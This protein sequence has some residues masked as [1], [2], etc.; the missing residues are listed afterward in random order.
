MYFLAIQ[1]VFLVFYFSATDTP[2]TRPYEDVY[3][4]NH[5]FFTILFFVY[6][7]R[8]KIMRYT[9]YLSTQIT[10]NIAEFSVAFA[11][12]PQGQNLLQ[13]E[14]KIRELFEGLN[15]FNGISYPVQE[16]VFCFRTNDYTKMMDEQDSW[17]NALL[18]HNEQVQMKDRNG[19]GPEQAAQNRAK[20]DHIIQ[21]ISLLEAKILAVEKEFREALS[22]GRPTD[23][24]MGKAYVVF[25]T[26]LA[27]YDILEKYNVENPLLYKLVVRLSIFI[28]NRLGVGPGANVNPLSRAL[29]RNDTYVDQ[30]QIIVFNHQQELSLTFQ[31]QK[32][33]V[34]K[35]VNPSNIIWSHFGYSY[36]RKVALRSLF[37]GFSLA[38]LG[39]SFS[40]VRTANNA[41]FEYFKTH[42]MGRFWRF[43]FNGLISLSIL[44]FNNILN[45][46]IIHTIQF[47]WHEKRTNELSS[48]IK[49]IVL[50][51]FLNTTIMIFLICF[52]GGSFD[53]G[54]LAYQVI[55]LAS[56]TAIISPLAGFWDF[57]YFVKLTR[58]YL[59]LKQANITETQA[60]LSRLWENPEY[61][62]VLNYSGFIF[63]F[64]N[65]S[66][67][68]NFFP[69]WLFLLILI[70]YIYNYSLQKWLFVRRN[71]V[72]NA[73]R[74]ELNISVLNLIDFAPLLALAAQYLRNRFVFGV[75]GI[76]HFGVI[77][78]LLACWTVLFPNEKLIDYF[79][80]RQY[81]NFGHYDTYREI[82][83]N[84]N[85]T[86]NN[87][88]YLPLHRQRGLQV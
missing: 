30:D 15:H 73:F 40:L 22:E 4:D 83:K 21:Q 19:E 80:L 75:L 48:M 57:S 87:P 25:K 17:K 11:N 12:L 67:Y 42:E 36:F 39:L 62:I 45:Q 81:R 71:S 14:D 47:E 76:N 46:F 7:L 23:R 6:W 41:R 51:M 70:Y 78:L 9:H 49:K 2:T 52:L 85:Y 50:K 69:F 59:I 56:I 33:Y 20:R 38:I 65:L 24:F 82:F 64:L 43:C 74:N 28:R 79:F 34:I 66:F 86:K 10:P 27:A 54:F 44:T 72:I 61:N 84:F 3:L 37:F 77:K 55:L 53:V 13:M 18:Y 29:M 5:F 58:R 26:Q 60:Y 1:L 88:A 8:Y 32:L 35:A 16:V 63:H 68:C 31:N